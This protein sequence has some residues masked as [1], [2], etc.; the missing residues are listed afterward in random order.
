MDPKQTDAADTEASF[1]RTAGLQ[2]AGYAVA[3][4]V[5]MGLLMGALQ[6]LA[7]SV[8]SST[9]N[10]RAVDRA[11]NSIS[12][13]TRQEPPQLNS[14]LA[15]DSSSGLIL[16]HVMEGLLRM[17]LNDRLVPAIAHDWELTDTKATFWLRDNARWSDGSTI[18][19]H[20]FIF[21]W[22]T[23][24]SP[25]LASEYAFLLYPIKN[26]RAINEGELPLSELGVSAPDDFTL[27]VEL[28]RPTAYFDKMVTFQT[29]FP[30]KESFYNATEGRFGADAWELL[31]S[32]P[33]VMKS[34][35][36][37][38]SI[39]ME[40]N[41]HYWDQE[42]RAKL[43]SINIA[44]ITDDPNARLNFFRDG[45]IAETYLVSENLHAGMK[46]RWHLKRIQDGTLFFLEFNH[47]PGR[48]TDNWHLRRAMQLVLDMEEL[49]Y[50][51]T[52][53]PGY[54]PGES[55]FPVWLQ[56]VED[57]FRI[58]HPAPELRLNLTEAKHHLELA[59]QELGLDEFPPLVLLSGDTPV[60]TL[61][62]EWVQAS[63]K[64]ALGLQIKIDKQIF[65]QR[66]AKMTA[67][68]FDMV[69][70]GWGPDYDDLM[71]FGDLFAS[72][73]L[74]NRGRYAND[75]M[76]RLIDVAQTSVDPSQRVEAFAGIQQLI[77][78]D[79]PILPMYERGLTYV[80]H[81]DLRDVKR[82]V[83]G[84]EIDFTY[85]YIADAD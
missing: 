85:A 34:W 40:R 61:H 7:S 29:Y 37:G 27:I 13:A 76:D 54:I 58:E 51:I 52:K 66:L 70:A 30:I 5:L 14:S 82:R 62:S 22:R 28:E 36:H 4:V 71:T 1:A 33:Y 9:D 35:I 23:A 3:A 50:K 83:V 31:Y 56:G 65:K 24:L 63:L 25:E 79:I 43:D 59:K 44:Y 72:W 15:T 84:P 32:G 55:L 49:V 74:N 57:K 81:P 26:A 47:R 73:N 16:N 2:L 41:P 75:E 19:A 77:F 38:A 48:L 68:E 42:N 80:V 10:A 67:G 18:T 64:E 6:L 69:L 39:L 78:D 20:D 11:N 53:L 60:S 46:N 17:D 12:I 8:G 21:A 45:R